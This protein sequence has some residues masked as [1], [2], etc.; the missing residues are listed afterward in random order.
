MSNLITVE[1][2]WSNGDNTI[3]DVNKN[4]DYVGYYMNNVFNIGGMTWNHKT[5][6]EEEEE[7]MVTALSVEVIE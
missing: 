6:E 3:T 1:V 5:D 2:N 7:I 4:S